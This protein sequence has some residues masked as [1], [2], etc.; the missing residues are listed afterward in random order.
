MYDNLDNQTTYEL[1]NL[2]Q[3]TTSLKDHSKN[4]C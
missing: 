2:N 1:D 4:N 3:N